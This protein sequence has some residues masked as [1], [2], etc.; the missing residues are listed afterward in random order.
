MNIEEFLNHPTPV[1]DVRSPSEFLQ[2][3]IPGAYSFPLFSD[4]E[5]AQVGLLYKQ[6]GKDA[7]VKLGLSFV[8]PKL[9][10]FV[11]NAEKMACSMKTFRIYCWRGGMRSSSLAWL[12]QTAG[13]RC[14]LLTSGYKAFRRWCLN[15]FKKQYSFIVLGG[16][17]GC[18]KTDFLGSLKQ[19][20]EQVIDLEAI[21]NHRG[22]SFGHLGCSDQPS[23]EHFENTLAVKLSQ[24]NSQLPIWIEDESRMIGTCPIPQDI[25][26]QMNQSSFLWIESSKEERIK[27]LL[28][29]YGHHPSEEMILAT[30]RLVRKLG[31]VRTKQVVELIQN[32]E[33]EIAISALLEYYDNSYIYSCQK[34]NRKQPEYTYSG[35]SDE[36]LEQLKDLSRKKSLIKECQLKSANR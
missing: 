12:L 25:W 18:G 2:G 29:I 30:Q 28:R 10:S 32:N 16:L 5:R 27:R 14:E 34:L 24:C 13:F 23:A 36:I 26:K 4:F 33:I 22:S 15:Q 11:E 35:C 19:Q 6:A 31:A 7:A 21:A 17:T 8:G 3:H 1:L 9:F 20:N